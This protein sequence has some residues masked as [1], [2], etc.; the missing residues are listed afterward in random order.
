MVSREIPESVA[1][2][3]QRAPSTPD[4]E[5]CVNDFVFIKSDTFMSHWYREKLTE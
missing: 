1:V 5:A 2:S 3:H 4:S